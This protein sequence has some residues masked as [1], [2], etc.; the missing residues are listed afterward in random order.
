MESQEGPLLFINRSYWPDVEATGQFLTELCEGL[1][2]Y[3]PIVVVAGRSYFLAD[4]FPPLRLFQDETHRGVRIVRVRHTRFWK[5]SFWGRMANWVTF[6]LL[7]FIAS[8]RLRPRLI[9]ACTDPPFSVFLAALLHRWKGI[10]FIFNCR[11]LYPDAALDLGKLKVGFLSRTFDRLHLRALRQASIVIPLGRSMADRIR[12][13]GLAGRPMKIIPDW[14]DTRMIRPIAK[15]N[16]PM[17]HQYAL[18]KPFIIMYS[19]NLGLSQDFDTI[20]QALSNLPPSPPWHLVLIGDGSGKKKLEEKVQALKFQNVLFLPYQPQEMLAYS[21]SM[22]NLHLVPLRKGMSGASVPSKVY[23][24][25][26]AGRPFLAITDRIS[27]PARL[28]LDLGLGL[29]APAG[30]VGKITQAI[31]WCLHHGEDLEA[32][33]EKGRKMAEKYF[34]KDVAIAEW[35]RTLRELLLDPASANLPHSLPLTHPIP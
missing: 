3:Y 14:A 15:R 32:M 27:E 22:A 12:I 6:I 13:K 20:L 16:N 9:V 31:R 25:M 11:D 26:A 19:G 4:R 10:P 34:D 7:A 29:W 21:L 24:I 33:G 2:E 18:E 30:D 23:G 8:W 5:G 1:G 35:R 17:I 28:A